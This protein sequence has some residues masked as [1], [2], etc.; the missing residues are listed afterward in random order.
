MRLSQLIQ[1]YKDDPYS[2]YKKLS[3]AVRTRRARLLARIIREHGNV[4]LSGIRVR[5]LAAWHRAWQGEDKISIAHA[6]I[7]RLRDAFRFG[8]TILEQAECVRL[9]AALK[10]MRFE[11]PR[12]R[13]NTMS[14][15]Y[16]IAIR[17]KAHCRG[18][19]YLALAQALQFEL[20][21]KP[22]DVIGEWIPISEPGKSDVVSTRKGKWISGL[23]WTD[24]DEQLVLRRA[25][26]K[27]RRLEAN[28]KSM[29]MVL[30]ELAKWVGVSPDEIMRAHLPASGPIILC[31]IN[32]WP[33]TTAEYRRKWRKVADQAGVPKHIQN[34]DNS[35]TDEKNALRRNIPRHAF[36]F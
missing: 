14:A 30:Q 22:K 8:A 28:L 13:L 3:Y 15:E 24:V 12:P 34:S 5:D 11:K 36:D 26:G 32:A 18:W 10:E 4:A 2:P 25:F 6:L 1:Q 7:S 9:L 27:R 35:R 16:A 21:L 20:G 31:E 29:P 33:Y 23:R 17:E 19:P